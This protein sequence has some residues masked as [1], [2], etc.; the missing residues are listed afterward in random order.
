M[1]TDVFSIINS[2]TDYLAALEAVTGEKTAFTKDEKAKLLEIYADTARNKFGFE[3][4]VL[5]KAVLALDVPGAN[6]LDKADADALTALAGLCA[7]WT[8][9]AKKAGPVKDAALSGDVSRPLDLAL[10]RAA[11]DAYAGQKDLA[12]YRE[13][14]KALA[15]FL[16][17]A[18][19]DAFGD[20][21]MFLIR[22]RERVR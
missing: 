21:S 4:G 17:D 9:D 19:E 12:P 2:K 8:P 1:K 16:K 18:D 6:L 3:D 11:L 14:I 20:A 15:E 7:D 10:A 13:D 5:V 22:V